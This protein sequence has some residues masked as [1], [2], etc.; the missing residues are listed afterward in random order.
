MERIIICGS[1]LGRRFGSSDRFLEERDPAPHGN[2][3]EPQQDRAGTGQLRRSR[4]RSVFPAF[5]AAV[6]PQMK[7]ERVKTSEHDEQHLPAQAGIRVALGRF[8]R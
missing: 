7:C 8:R 6:R 2:D 3:S 4:G 1:R 5:D